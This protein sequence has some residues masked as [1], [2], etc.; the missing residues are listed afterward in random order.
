MPNCCIK[1]ARGSAEQKNAVCLSDLSKFLIAQ[2]ELSRGN[3][4][5][6]SLNIYSGHFHQRSFPL[7][8]ETFMD[9]LDSVAMALNAW[10]QATYIREWFR[11]P[12]APRAGLPSRPRVDTAVT[13]RLNNSPSW[14]P[15][16]AEKWFSS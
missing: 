12:P 7:S 13:V 2:V 11:Q 1:A 10:G 14:D 3:L 6:V 4:R 5:I 9:K 8:K 16:V 15:A